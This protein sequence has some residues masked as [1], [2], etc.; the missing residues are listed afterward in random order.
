MTNAVTTAPCRRH[1]PQWLPISFWGP[2]RY[3]YKFKVI[4]IS[5]V[6]LL[7]HIF[8]CQKFAAEKSENLF[9]LGSDNPDL[10]VYLLILFNLFTWRGADVRSSH[11]EPVEPQNSDGDTSDEDDENTDLWMLFKT[12]RN[13]TTN[14]G[15]CLS[16]PF[17]RLPS[18]RFVAVVR[19][20]AFRE[21]LEAWKC[22][23]VQLRSLK[24][25]G[26]VGEF[27]W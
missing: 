4:S 9:R 11:T 22:R 14:L 24:S 7:Q 18:K 10:Y 21:F 26:K 5:L 2:Y 15:L 8:R 12:V 25:L 23:A 19:V 6:C 20:I 1:R 17:L 3:K 16:E 13:Y 27:V